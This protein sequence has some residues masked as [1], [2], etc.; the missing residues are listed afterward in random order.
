[1][2]KPPWFPKRYSELENPHRG[3]IEK[4]TYGNS[5]SKSLIRH[6]SGCVHDPNQFQEAKKKKLYFLEWNVERN[7]F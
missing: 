6:H 4:S 1:M 5:N 7:T 2:G 3:A